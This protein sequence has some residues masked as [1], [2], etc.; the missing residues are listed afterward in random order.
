MTDKLL[1]KEKLLSEVR[2]H[3]EKLQLSKTIGP[4][5]YEPGMM[6]NPE[7]YL[8]E[9]DEELGIIKLR[10]DVKGLRYENRTQKLDE[11]RAGDAVRIA[12]DGANAFNP[13]NFAVLTEKGE[14][15]G[16]LSAELCNALCIARTTAEKADIFD[17]I[18]FY[19]KGYF[20]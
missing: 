5:Y 19:I 7:R 16:S 8:G 2:R 11:L 4:D 13:N 12:R 20:H 6:E 3:D 14:S 9:F 1:E 10:T 17:N 18:I 15:L